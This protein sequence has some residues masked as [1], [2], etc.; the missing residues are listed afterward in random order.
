MV[1]VG[2]RLSDSWQHRGWGGVLMA[3]AERIAS[4]EYGVEKLLVMSALGTKRYYE[5]LGYRRDGVYVSK[6]L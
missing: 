3:E 4:E 1:P 2:S 5:R 6:P